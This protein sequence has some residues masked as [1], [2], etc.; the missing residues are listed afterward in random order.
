MSRRRL[1]RAG[2]F[3]TCPVGPVGY[4]GWSR[5]VSV[6]VA[7][8]K[9]VRVGYFDCFSGT[10]GDMTMAALVD[11]GVDRRAIQEGVASLGLPV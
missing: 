4:N 8:G 6:F 5:N 1:G 11:A 9:G 3:L 10:A 2:L 7:R